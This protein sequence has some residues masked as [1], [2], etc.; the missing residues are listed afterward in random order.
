M[1]MEK[2]KIERQKDKNILQFLFEFYELGGFV[3]S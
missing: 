3:S 2:D 1:E